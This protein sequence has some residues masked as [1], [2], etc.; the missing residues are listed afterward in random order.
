MVYPVILEIYGNMTIPKYW[1]DD[2]WYDDMIEDKGL[3]I[4]VKLCLASLYS[5][6]NLSFFYSWNLQPFGSDSLI[7]PTL[8]TI[9]LQM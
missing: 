4:M 6:S 5:V 8:L 2:N 7:P 1:N 3:I 9:N